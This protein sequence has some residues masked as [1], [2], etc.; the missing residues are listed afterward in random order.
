LTVFAN[1][2]AV[3]SVAGEAAESRFL[4]RLPALLLHTVNTTQIEDLVFV[5][6]VSSPKAAVQVGVTG[7]VRAAVDDRPVKTYGGT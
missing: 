4:E 3:A 2:S 7:K 5:S 6:Q 1:G